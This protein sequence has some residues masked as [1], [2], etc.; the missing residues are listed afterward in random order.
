MKSNS[1]PKTLKRPQIFKKETTFYP[2]G[3]PKGDQISAKGKRRHR[4][5]CNENFIWETLSKGRPKGD[6]FGQKSRRPGDLGT[7]LS[8]SL[9]NDLILLLYI[10]QSFAMV[11]EN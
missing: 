6:H 8:Q 3:R 2:K 9:Q 11:E 7:L 5:F 1:V 10:N 4:H